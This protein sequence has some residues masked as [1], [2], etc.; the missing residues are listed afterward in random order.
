MSLITWN[1]QF[2]V[3]VEEIDS[4]HKKLVQLIN[5]LHAHILAGDAK[6][7]MGTVLDRMIEYTAFHFETEEKLMKKYGYP[8][9]VAHTEEHKKLVATALELQRKFKSG[10]G[11]IT[12]ETM[13]FLRDWLQH[14]IKESDKVLGKHLLSHG[15]AATVAAA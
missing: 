13:A 11:A 3:G 7:I 10:T 5:G 15:V 9:S 4:Q 14:H 6:H 12:M 8:A 2:S 1:D